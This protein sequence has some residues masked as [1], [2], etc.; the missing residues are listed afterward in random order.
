MSFNLMNIGTS[1]IR[2]S[3]E[4]LQTTSKN[5]ANLNTE[6]YV[7]ER[8]EH[9]TLSNGQVGRGETVRLLNEFAQRQLNRDISNTTFYEQFV[10]EAER[11]DLL[12]A[13]E[14]NSLANSINS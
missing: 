6:G 3:T 14:S 8:T 13:E 7:R 1:G 11:V 2:S 12:F 4:L 9:V 5:I 10:N